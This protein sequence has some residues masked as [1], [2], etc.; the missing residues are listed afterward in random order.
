MKRK[1]ILLLLLSAGAAPLAPHLYADTI[2]LSG[3]ITEVERSG[4]H[5]PETSVAVG[6]PFSGTV[7]FNHDRTRVI[8]F[9]TIADGDFYY[10]SLLNPNAGSLVPIPGGYQFE[11]SAAVGPGWGNS[12]NYL[13]FAYGTDVNSLYANSCNCFGDASNFIGVT[14]TINSFRVT[15]PD[16]TTT[17]VLLSLSVGTLMVWRR[18][19]I[20]EAAQ[21]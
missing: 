18:C 9:I 19:G 15:T 4:E 16:D 5:P 11:F 3:I 6:D 21:R 14:G 20:T 8:A 12:D 2:R 17:I 13:I 10:S 7:D 1:L